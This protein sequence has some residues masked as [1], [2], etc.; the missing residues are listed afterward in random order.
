MARRRPLRATDWRQE[1]DMT[2]RDRFA[3]IVRVARQ[4]LL[5]GAAVAAAPG[6]ARAGFIQTNLVS[7][8]QGM[9]ANTDPNLRNP[10][11]ISSAG[12]SPVWV[13]NQVTGNAT[14]YNGAGTPQA[15][16]VTIPGGNPTGQVFNSTGG[17]ALSNGTNATFLFATLGGT[18]TGWNNAAGNTALVAATGAVGSDYTRLAQGTNA[19]GNFLY[20]ANDSKGRI[21]VFNSS[22]GSTSLGGNFTD[23]NLPATFTPYN[24]QNLGGTLYVTY[25]SETQ[26]GGVVDAFD[27]NGNFL[28]RISANG[29]GGP[30]ASPWGLALAPAGFGPF[31]GALLVGNEDDGHISAFNPTTG[32]FLGQLLTDSGQ[33]IANP[34]LWGLRFGTG[35]NSGNPNT[36]YIA[37][38]I[39]GEHDGLFGAISVSVPA[40]AG[41]A[42]LAPAAVCLL[43]YGGRRRR[44]R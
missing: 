43:G 1:V 19:S 17:F 8:I 11:G 44:V 42:L 20:A 7:N 2:S 32:A 12:T 4:A 14:L 16:V 35:G 9:A 31:G 5:L 23:P 6:G 22:F 13:S 27:T 37:A 36:L 29:A 26:G 34:G 41:L 33:P 39:N 38:G 28:R 3:T 24:I 10:W 21:D 30:L 18:I 15:L 25:E 40:P